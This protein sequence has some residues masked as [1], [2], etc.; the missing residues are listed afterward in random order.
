MNPTVKVLAECMWGCHSI[1]HMRSG[2]YM[3][4]SLEWEERRLLVEL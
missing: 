1:E 3:D 4:S 2:H